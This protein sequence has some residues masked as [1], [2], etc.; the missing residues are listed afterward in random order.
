MEEV[1]R[2]YQLTC[3]FSTLQYLE[4]QSD[5]CRAYLQYLQDIAQNTPRFSSFLLA[6]VCVYIYDIGEYNWHVYFVYVS[7]CVLDLN[8]LLANSETRRSW[9]MGEYS[10]FLCQEESNIECLDCHK[11]WFCS[12]VVEFY[13]NIYFVNRSLDILPG[14]LGSDSQTSWHKNMPAH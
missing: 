11:A 10:C 7:P 4:S 2:I 3:A 9:N 1:V 12:Q 6:R 14:T 8:I 5:S 13:S